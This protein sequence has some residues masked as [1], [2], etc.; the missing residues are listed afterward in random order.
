MEAVNHNLGRKSRR[1]QL[2]G[3]A[4]ALAALVFYFLA[5]RPPPAPPA[6]AAGAAPFSV[7]AAQE[8]FPAA[9]ALSPAGKGLY[10]VADAHGAPLGTLLHSPELVE[11]I[12]GYSGP[13]PLLIGFG[14]DG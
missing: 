1:G 10:K 12:Q 5:V 14:P 6:P 9:A 7:A 13:T 2:L 8:V 4:A 11:G 3:G